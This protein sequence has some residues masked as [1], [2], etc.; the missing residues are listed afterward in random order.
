MSGIFSEAFKND[1]LGAIFAVSVAPPEMTSAMNLNDVEQE[2]V[3]QCAQCVE[4]IKK[5]G[6]PRHMLRTDTPKL[7][8]CKHIIR[9]KQA[10]KIKKILRKFLNRLQTHPKERAVLQKLS[11]ETRPYINVPYSLPGKEW[12]SK[13]VYDDTSSSDDVMSGVSTLSWDES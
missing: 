2:L 1:I 13:V 10:G 9:L 6:V 3:R 12:E 4:H 5:E 8:I 7:K 11:E